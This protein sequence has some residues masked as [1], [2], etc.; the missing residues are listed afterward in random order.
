MK[1]MK[2]AAFLLIAGVFIAGCKHDPYGLGTATANN[3]TM[4]GAQEVPEVP[5]TATGT[6]QASYNRDTRTLEYTVTWTGLTGPA[7]AMHIHGPADPG[8]NAGI[9]QNI[10]ATGSISGGATIANPGTAY[11]T[12]GN[13]SARAFVDN[14]VIKESD[15]LAGKYYI[16]IHT[17]KYPGGEIRGNLIF[18]Q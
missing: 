5:T 6:I 11:G 17:A 16:N 15:L 9:L 13:I 8:T 12:S 3:I 7:A 10:I 2:L 18:T 14:V 4:S 1:M